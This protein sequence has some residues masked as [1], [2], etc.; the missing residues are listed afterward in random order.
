MVNK[1]Y[2]K[3][4]NFFKNNWQMLIVIIV[5]LFACLYQFPYTISKPGGII[6]T[7]DKV[8]I[9]SS[10]KM[11]GSLNMAYVSEVPSNSIFMLLSF[12]NKDWDI[13]KY[14][15]EVFTKQEE[16]ELNHLMLN[17]ANNAAYI[18]ALEASSI[19]Y[20][21]ENNKVYVTYIYEDAKTN[22]EVGDQII[23]LND[24]KINNKEELYNIASEYK[25]GDNLTFTVIHDGK[26]KKRTATLTDFDGEAKVGILLYESFKIKTGKNVEFKFK[27][28]ESGG[29]GGLMMTLT[30]YSYLNNIDLTKGKKIV[31]TGTIDADGNVGEIAGV[32]Y[33]LLGAVKENADI[34]LVPKGTNYKEAVKIKKERNLD[35]KIVSIGSFDEALKYLEN[36]S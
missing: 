18:C 6:D 10:L 35:I 15:E 16:D 8:E 12:L 28:S 36:I 30:L 5:L 25:V 7:K 9:N 11:N 1:L 26:K 20:E 17:E 23:K 33:K 32:K 13:E 22:L 27:D 34:F 29:S 21:K 31:G 2:D 14:D 3:I 24:K 19:S 4:K